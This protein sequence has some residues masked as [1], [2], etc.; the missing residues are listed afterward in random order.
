VETALS[1]ARLLDA[2]EQAQL[3]DSLIGDLRGDLLETQQQPPADALAL[4]TRL[5]DHARRPP[6]PPTAGGRCSP[7]RPP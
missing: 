1:A 7:R 3:L 5:A 6:P 2:N 4:A